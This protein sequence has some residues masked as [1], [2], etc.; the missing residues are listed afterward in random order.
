MPFD[1]HGVIKYT[2]LSEER[3][4]FNAFFAN[5]FNFYA[6]SIGHFFRANKND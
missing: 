4:V 2:V 5:H 1:C 3:L 6:L